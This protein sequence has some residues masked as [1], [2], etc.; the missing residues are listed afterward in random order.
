MSSGIQASHLSSYCSG[1]D[2]YAAI[3]GKLAINTHV[4]LFSLLLEL[5]S[6]ASFPLAKIRAIGTV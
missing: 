5:P 4:E 3:G 1:H 2:W 6:H